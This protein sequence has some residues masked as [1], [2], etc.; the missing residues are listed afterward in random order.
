MIDSCGTIHSVVFVHTDRTEQFEPPASLVP[1]DLDINVNTDDAWKLFDVDVSCF[2]QYTCPTCACDCDQPSKR[3]VNVEHVNAGGDV[4]LEREVRDAMERERRQSGCLCSKIVPCDACRVSDNR[5]FVVHDGK[6]N[7][8]KCNK[9]IQVLHMSEI[10]LVYLNTYIPYVSLSNIL[11]SI[12]RLHI[13]DI[14]FYVLYFLF[15]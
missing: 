13:G 12:C 2:V 4:D 6:N 11:G 3:S 8:K 15:K 14:K 9:I 7:K 10:S 5:L 1:P